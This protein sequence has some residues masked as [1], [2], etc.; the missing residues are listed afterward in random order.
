MEADLQKKVLP[1]FHYTLNP[2]GYLFLGTS[3]TIGDAADRFSVVDSTQAIFRRKE[4]RGYEPLPHPAGALR[5][6]KEDMQ[7]PQRKALPGANIRELAE[8]TILRTYAPPCV[9]VDENFDILYFH[10]DT[11]RFLKL[12]EGEPGFNILKMAREELRYKLTAILQKASA[13]KTETVSQPIAMTWR[14]EAMT[15]NVVVRPVSDVSAKEGLLL[16]IFES[17]EPKAGKEAAPGGKRAAAKAHG[18][19]P[20]IEALEHELQSTKEHLHTTIEEL[21][22]SNEELKSTNEELQSTNEELQS[23]NEELETSREELQSANE[24]LE[25][26]NSE[27]RD[28]FEALTDANNDLNNLLG[29]TD[30]AT[31]FLDDSLNIRRFTAKARELFKLIVTDVGRPITDVATTLEY[32]NV[33]DDIKHVLANL[34]RVEKEVR[35]KDG[36][37]FILRILPYRTADNVI[38]GVVVTFPEITEQKRSQTQAKEAKDFAESIIAT[39]HEPLA[40]LDKSLRVLSVNQ[41]FCDTFKVKQGESEGKLIYELGS[42]Q[43]DIPELRK[44]LKEILPKSTEV[45]DFKVEYDFP[46]VGRKKMMLNARRLMR[47]HEGTETILLAMEELGN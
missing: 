8:R 44:L 22:T 15:A 18:N 12:P 3:E 9:L 40:V 21:E 14:D 20:R 37:W 6:R 30:V 27:L 17:L 32:D 46:S 26:V 23:T 41:S 38:D 29:S 33:V 47:G 34:G 31:L 42:R 1:L 36:R 7:Q 43:W 10:G 35:S 5:E 45:K 25:T 13:E 16:V 11:E 19:E 28:K 2:G 24:E 4:G 39:I